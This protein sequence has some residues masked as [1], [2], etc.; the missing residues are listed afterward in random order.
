M[1]QVVYGILYRVRLLVLCTCV[2]AVYRTSTVLSLVVVLVPV[3]EVST[4]L[5]V[6]RRRCVLTVQCASLIR[7]CMIILLNTLGERVSLYTVQNNLKIALRT[8][9]SRGNASKV[10]MDVQVRG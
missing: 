7:M 4:W 5:A 10:Y 8:P 3:L 9:E 6:V 1:Y 2:A